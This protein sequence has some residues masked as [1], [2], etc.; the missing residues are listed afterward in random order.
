MIRK[1]FSVAGLIIISGTAIAYS[2]V[3]SPGAAFTST[4][5]SD[6]TAD[7][8]LSRQT[9]AQ[10]AYLISAFFGLD[11]DLPRSANFG[12]CAGAG[13]ADGMPVV[14]SREIDLATLQAG[15]FQV[16]TK[17]GRTGSQT[18]V[19]LLPAIDEGELR[20]VLLV[21]DLGS[22]D[23]DPPVRV[24][25]IGNLHSI[26]QALNFRGAE[27]DVTPLA[28]GPSLF[29]Q[30]SFPNQAGIWDVNLAG[31]AAPVLAVQWTASRRS[32][33]LIGRAERHLRMG[34]SR[35][36]RSAVFTLSRWRRPTVRFVM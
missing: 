3:L 16:R 36:M 15:D 20:T 1:I 21:G 31:V 30:K 4:E 23:S 17:S 13:G 26:D 9:E 2:R 19:T 8:S 12:I 27:V 24:K 5:Q 22:A 25:I 29:F 34:K 33:A 11:G 14:F 6:S 7:Y 35:V 10:S 32:C 18:C 28:Q